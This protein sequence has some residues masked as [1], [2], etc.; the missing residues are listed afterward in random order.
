MGTNACVTAA[1]VLLTI[2]NIHCFMCPLNSWYYN[3]CCLSPGF[4]CLS[5]LFSTYKH[6]SSP[7][8]SS[9]NLHLLVC[10]VTWTLMTDRHQLNTGLTP[11]ERADWQQTHKSGKHKLKF[12][13]HSDRLRQ[14]PQ[15]SIIHLV[16]RV[17]RWLLLLMR[18]PWQNSC[19]HSSHLMTTP[20]DAL[21]KS[22]PRNCPIRTALQFQC[23]YQRLY[24]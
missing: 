14:L 13:T 20:W 5:L 2:R 12:E 15:C 8:C 22:L 4:S 18:L 19:S 11:T 23:R 16:Q 7:F 17:H 9:D 3:I 10:K 1:E 6:I 24:F 21:P